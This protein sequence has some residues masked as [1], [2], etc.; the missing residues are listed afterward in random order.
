MKLIHLRFNIGTPWE[1][2]KNLGSLHGRLGQH[3]AWELEH[4]YYAGSLV[5]VEFAVS[6]GEDHA[7][8]E[9]GLGLL[10]YGIGFRVYDTRHWNT[11][12]NTWVAY[13]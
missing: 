5:D 11:T 1:L 10:G 4:T 13:D 12:L 9:L 2:F 8:L 3:R 7:G 6:T